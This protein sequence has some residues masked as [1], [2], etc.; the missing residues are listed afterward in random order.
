MNEK[1]TILIADDERSIRTGL[2][3]IVER[4]L[5]QALVVGC[6]D[7]GVKALDILTRYKPDIAILDINMPEMDGLEVIRRAGEQALPTRFLIL[8]GYEEFA[9]AQKAI[10]YGVKSYFLKPLDMEEFRA[11]LLQQCQEVLAG[12]KSAPS[13]TA[14]LAR[15]VESSRVLFLNRLLGSRGGSNAAA[16]ESLPLNIANGPNCVAVFLLGRAPGAPAAAALLRE[17]V[18]P[19]FF[20]LSAEC[21]LHEDD[22]I[23]VLFNVPAG[24]GACPADLRARLVQ[25]AGEMRRRGARVDVGL[26]DVAPDWNQTCHSFSLAQ[27]ALTYRIYSPDIDVY[28]PGVITQ[29]RSAFSRDSIDFAPLID[30]ILEHDAEGIRTYCDAFFQ[31]LLYVK[32]PPPSFVVGMCMYLVLNTQKQIQ[33]RQPDRKLELEFSYDELNDYDSLD[34]MRGW[35]YD[36]FARYS[37]LIRDTDTGDNRLIRTAKEY[38]RDHLS[39]N[40]KARDVAAQVNL[41]EA[42]FTI[43]FKEKTGVNFRDYLLHARIEQAKRLLRSQNVNVSEVAYRTGYQDYRSF[44]RAFKHETGL[45]P[46]EYQNRQKGE[47]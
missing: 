7:T 47:K 21:W 37:E 11:A 9:Y 8:S 17:V 23:V 4:L 40:L 34:G 42:Y 38:I 36:F 24:S 18:A 28:D 45:T 30:A 29:Q 33:E 6:V 5:E 13:D 22:Q 27:E 46:S 20:G 2:K 39:S 25:C 32:M 31:A 35:L 43:Y 16:M 14:T 12:R 26:G 19:A 3:A 1:V 10:R 15:L 44:S 41:S